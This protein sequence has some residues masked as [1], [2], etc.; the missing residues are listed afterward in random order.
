MGTTIDIGDLPPEQ[1]R[2]VQEFVEFLKTRTRGNSN[3]LREGGT[4]EPVFAAWP[5]GVKS[6][7]SREEIYDHL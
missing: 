5:L 4:E 2:I 3:L 7:L 6:R 1:A